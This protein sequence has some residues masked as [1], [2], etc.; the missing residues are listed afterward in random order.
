MM[1][2]DQSAISAHYNT[3]H[4][5]T[6]TRARPGEGSHACDVCGRKYAQKDKL[7]LHMADVHGIGELKTFECHLCQRVFKHKHHLKSHLKRVHKA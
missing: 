1:F 6:T 7:K 4:G 3:A 5:N 2:L